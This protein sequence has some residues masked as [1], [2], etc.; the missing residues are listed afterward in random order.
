MA[1]NTEALYDES[2]ILNTI[3]PPCKHDLGITSP[4]FQTLLMLFK[5]TKF[6][7]RKT[8]T[9]IPPTYPT[10]SVLMSQDLAL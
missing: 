9:H 7:D 1:D 3:F 10:V 5:V 6:Q 4:A 2:K 8:C